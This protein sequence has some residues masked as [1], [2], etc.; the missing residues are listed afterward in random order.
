MFFDTVKDEAR[1]LDKY[2]EIT[3]YPSFLPNGIPAEA[4]DK[5]DADRSIELAQGVVEFVVERLV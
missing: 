4:F 2:Y 5:V 3:R 1:Q